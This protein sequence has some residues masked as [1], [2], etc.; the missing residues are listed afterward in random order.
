MAKMKNMFQNTSKKTH[1]NIINV[2]NILEVVK[3]S[4]EIPAIAYTFKARSNECYIVACYM[5]KS[6]M[7][8]CDIVAF[9]WP[10]M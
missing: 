7:S 8:E 6:R 5:A 10:G 1:E 9:V 2:D 3:Y 4:I